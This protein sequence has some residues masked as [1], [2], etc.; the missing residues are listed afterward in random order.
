MPWPPPPPPKILKYFNILYIYIYICYKSVKVGPKKN[1]IWPPQ[2][3]L[4][5][6]ILEKKLASPKNKQK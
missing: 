3:E 6:I 4:S 5:P 2:I 1:E